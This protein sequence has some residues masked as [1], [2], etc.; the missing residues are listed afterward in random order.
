MI[1]RMPR[2]T[3]TFKEKDMNEDEMRRADEI[4]RNNAERDRL[5]ALSKPIFRPPVPPA[6]VQF[7]DTLLVEERNAL[8]ERVRQLAAALEA[9][10]ET[11]DS[12]WQAI[13]HQTIARRALMP[14]GECK[15]P[16]T[17]SCGYM[18]CPC[19]CHGHVLCSD[20]NGMPAKVAGRCSNCSL[21]SQGLLPEQLTLETALQRI[22]DLL[23]DG[24]HPLACTN[25]G[26]EKTAE[27][28]YCRE[29]RASRR[30]LANAFLLRAREAA[31]EPAKGS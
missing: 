24:E 7:M 28:G 30:S 6:Q 8:R 22:E 3:A 26:F 11:P 18:E 13:S 16:A 14:P 25:L 10:A 2:N 1:D 9:I 17:V 5:L 12:D 15:C 19:R 4:R 21:R 23:R 20:C 31:A 29:A 27:C